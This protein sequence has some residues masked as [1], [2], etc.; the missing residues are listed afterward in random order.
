MPAF[1]PLAFGMPNLTEA[2]LER[3]FLA[4]IIVH[5][6]TERVQTLLVEGIRRLG[7]RVRVYRH[8]HDRGTRLAPEKIE[9]TDVEPRILP[10]DSGVEM[11]RHQLKMTFQLFC[12]GRVAFVVHDRILT[13]L[14]TI[15]TPTRRTGA[16]ARVGQRS[17]CRD[18]PG[19]ELTSPSSG[20]RRWPHFV[21]ARSCGGYASATQSTS[22]SNRPVHSGT[23]T[24]MRGGS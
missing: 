10:G 2:N 24:K 17:G 1:A 23:T 9:V 16:L 19:V 15:G 5:I 21:G 3:H 11:M 14:R 22:M 13:S 8:R 18:R 7:S 4:S 6:E 12:L 20:E